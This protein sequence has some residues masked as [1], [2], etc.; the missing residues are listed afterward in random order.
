MSAIIDVVDTVVY[1]LMFLSVLYLL[2][3]AFFSQFHRNVDLST[4]KTKK[5]I[6]VLLPAYKEDAVVKTSVASFLRQQ[7]PCENYDLVV[8]ADRFQTSTLEELRKERIILLEVNFE[9]ST[10]A[11][12]MNYAMDYL[13]GTEKKYDIVV[14][15]DADNEVET[16]FL[17][18]INAGYQKNFMAMQTHR[19]AKNM[20]TDTAVL[21][22]VSE[23]INNSIFRS[24]HVRL[25][26]SS[27]LIGSGM[28]FDYKW[29]SENVKKTFTAGEDK[30]LERLLL[31]QGV[32]V[33]YLSQVSVYDQKTAKDT[34]FYNQRRRWLGA[35]FDMFFRCAK[36]LLGSILSGNIDYTDKLLQ[37]MML[38]RV[39][40]LGL[41]SI[42]AVIWTV[43]SWTYSLKWWF[44]LLLISFAL[45]F[46]VPDYL[47]N[48]K[49]YRAMRK[50]PYMALMMILS[51]M[52][53][54]GSTKKFIHTQH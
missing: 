21:D 27:A 9:N 41:I 17:E 49:F 15:L 36:D 24:G 48:E 52:H 35:Q 37:W 6:A 47:V 50:I 42:F 30:E 31:S 16:D 8:I 4:V 40:L 23:E 26:F 34:N 28:A 22:A 51:M 25:G 20:D 43:F 33:A 32:Y 2:V 44:L 1:A 11:K 46:A 53:L 45:A 12:A 3:F 38:P 10:K 18:R 29:F 54:K 7:Y 5:N 39:V 19:C 14:V 13:N